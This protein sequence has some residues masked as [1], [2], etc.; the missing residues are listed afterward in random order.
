MNY[1]TEATKEDGALKSNPFAGFEAYSTAPLQAGLE[2]DE[3][4]E[5]DNG[6]SAQKGVDG[7]KAYE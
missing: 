7:I 6:P 5:G 1:Q 3:A 4:A 2:S